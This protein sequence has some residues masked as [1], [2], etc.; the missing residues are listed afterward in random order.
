ML[1]KD[2]LTEQITVAEA[3]ERNMIRGI[4]FGF[5]HDEWQAFTGQMQPDDELWSFFSPP[6]IWRS[7]CG[8]A[9]FAVVRNGE[10]VRCFMT[11]LN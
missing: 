5:C 3:E 11:M 10:A 8:R 2:W 4:S 9:G 6:E 1:P 7:L